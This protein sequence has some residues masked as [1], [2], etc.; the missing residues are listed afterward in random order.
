MN[1]IRTKAAKT[2]IVVL[3]ALGSFAAAGPAGAS[4]THHAPT[5]ATRHAKYR[6]SNDAKYRAKY[7]VTDDAKYRAKYR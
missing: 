4:F 2:S 7:R 3:C 6:A 1:S 5:Q